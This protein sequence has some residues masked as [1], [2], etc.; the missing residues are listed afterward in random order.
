MRE[1]AKISP[2]I[3]I[4]EHGRKIKRMGIEAQLVSIYLLTNP[5]ANMI[6]IY[7]LPIAFIAHE[8]GL[9]ED[10]T[11][12]SITKLCG[13]G[14][15]DYDFKSEYVWVRDMGAT[16]IAPELSARDHRVKGVN[17]AY[18]ALPELPFLGSFYDKYVDVFLLE[19]HPLFLSPLQGASKPL[20]SKEKENEKENDNENKKENEMA[21]GSASA[22]KYL[23]L[24]ENKNQKE[25][26]GKSHGFREQATEVL[27]FLNEVANKAFEPTIENLRDIIERLIQGE[28]VDVCRCVIVKKS[29]QWLNDKKMDSN[30]N[31]VTLF[32]SDNF[33]R[34]KGELVM[35]KESVKNDSK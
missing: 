15:C 17:E 20:A 3:W 19:K 28:T 2:Q 23:T 12:Q 29:R 5:H 13:I 4:S 11:S 8:V 7:Y 14:Y 18:H 31:P 25:T 33:H 16:Q 30:L 32:K 26:R 6:G 21:P 24:H 9:S 10:M 1:F 22:K 35:P 27:Q 34:Y